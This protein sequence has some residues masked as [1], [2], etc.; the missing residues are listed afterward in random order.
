MRSPALLLA[1]ALAGCLNHGIPRDRSVETTF[2]PAGPMLARQLR[3]VTFNVHGE[4]G[5]R[6]A[7]ALRADPALAAADVILLQEV[8]R[9]E[10]RGDACS[11]A[12]ELGWQL[13]WH[14]VFAPGHAIAKGSH[15]VAILARAPITST[16]VIELPY[17]DVHANRGRRVALAATLD[18][19]GQPV[20]V[21]A[22]HLDNRLTVA[23]RR[24]QVLPVLIHAARHDTPVIIGGDFNTS[25]FT[26]LAHLIPIPIG[27][28][29][30]NLEALVRAFGFATPVTTS[31]PTHEALAMR[32]D[33]IYTR[34][35]ETT[36]FAV[37]D[38]DRISDHLALWADVRLD[39]D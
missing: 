37:Q 30:S 24:A 27:T 36:R 19:D 23:D 13:G 12:C 29:A 16:Q 28:Q 32:L 21:Y 31:G 10:R 35:F 3:V 1:S 15:G 5:H 22:V 7:R 11:A 17:F 20:T 9:D 25:P 18:V 34:G 6:I 14:A 38:A 26:W 33:A 4:P 2:P 39:S 8:E